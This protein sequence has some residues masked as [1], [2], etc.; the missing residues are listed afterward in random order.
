[1]NPDIALFHLINNIAGESPLLDW[2][3]RAVVN[4]YAVPVLMSL[5]LGG[6]WFSGRTPEEG[7]SNQRAVLLAI[8]GLVITNVLIR[9][10]Q[11]V[12]FRP[13]P[14]ATETVKL[15]FYRPS[16]SS[17]PS[18]PVATMFC[19]V[20]AVWTANRRVGGFLLALALL[21]GLARVL[22]G[23]HYPSDIIGGALL[24]L[25]CTWLPMRYSRFVY[26]PLD[27]V[28]RFGQQLNLA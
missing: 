14:F 11:E 28:I 9:G 18:E 12:Y 3:T 15:L 6:F 7:W 25:F 8:L 19:F 1:M 27:A 13:R 5:T 26:R 24:G 17:F 4:D 23:V 2:L 16:V 22:A 21:F 10:L 20:T